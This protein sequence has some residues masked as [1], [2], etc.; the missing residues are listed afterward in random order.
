MVR[1][2]AEL[3]VSIRVCKKQ[4]KYTNVKFDKSNVHTWKPLASDQGVIHK[5]YQKIPLIVIH[6]VA[7][8]KPDCFYYSFPAT[9]MTK[10]R[11]GH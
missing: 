8:K 4:A 11:V 3:L 10:R 6:G 2:C 9:S 7:I 1:K 5:N